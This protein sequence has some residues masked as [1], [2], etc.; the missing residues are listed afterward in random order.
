ME[1]NLQSIFQRRIK[2][3]FASKPGQWLFSI[4]AIAFTGLVLGMLVWRERSVL[5][6]YQ[7]SIDFQAIV[8]AFLV[9]TAALFLASFIWVRI[10]S[11]MGARVSFWEHF[12]LFCISML[13]KRLPGTVWYVVY[14][15]QVYQKEGLS[16]R[17]TTLA[18]GFEYALMMV[19]S[20]L[21]TFLFAIP[22][23]K[24]NSTQF[25]LVII[26]FVLFASLLHPRVLGWSLR[27]LGKVNQPFEYRK[28]I[29][30]LLFYV[31]LRLLSGLLVFYIARIIYPVPW[32][33]ALMVIGGWSLASVITNLLLFFPSNMGLTEV[34]FSL[35][36]SSIMPSSIAVVAAVL[37]RIVTMSFELLWALGSL[38]I[39][40]WVSRMRGAA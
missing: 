38:A 4:A 7:W 31:G 32:G 17:L 3:F 25:W 30:W 13:A 33:D 18:S 2:P 19:S 35:V 34:T 23:I 36:L 15:N 29:I 28:V 40:Q 24:L 27:R 12:R 10:V 20:I 22:L 26:A 14:R 9:Y 21:V 1:R 5:F 8:S 11:A 6:R 39:Q 16:A 37:T